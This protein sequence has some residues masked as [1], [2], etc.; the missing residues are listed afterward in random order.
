M[1]RKAAGK[2]DKKRKGG[3]DKGLSLDILLIFQFPMACYSVLISS[4]SILYL[5]EASI[6]RRSIETVQITS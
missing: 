5:Q 6:S 2:G 1:L 4:H 3:Y